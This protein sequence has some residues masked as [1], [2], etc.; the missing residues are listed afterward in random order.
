MHKY[1]NGECPTGLEASW[2][3]FPWERY[4]GGVDV[5][6]AIVVG[7]SLLLIRPS[8]W[9]ITMLTCPLRRGQVLANAV[10]ESMAELGRLGATLNFEPGSV[11]Q[12]CASHDDGH[13]FR[14]LVLLPCIQFGPTTAFER[15]NDAMMLGAYTSHEVMSC[16]AAH[17]LGWKDA[18][19]YLPLPSVLN[20][21]LAQAA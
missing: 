16:Y 15:V 20:T 5:S 2:E 6:F 13:T 7:R 18:A 1:I 10:S 3:T 4:P 12:V 8:R 21:V 11:P 14:V 9:N 19:Q 17:V